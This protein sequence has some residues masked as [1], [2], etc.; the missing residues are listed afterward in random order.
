MSA[1]GGG[2]KVRLFDILGA[3]GLMAILAIMILPIPPALLSLLLIVNLAL[4][5]TVLLVATTV[6]DVLEFSVFPSV[7]LGLTLLRL[8]LN[9][10]STKL[11]LLTGNPGS[12]VEAFGKVVVRGDAVVEI[13]RASC[14]ER[15]S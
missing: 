9:L 7:L 5:V 12:V 10:A 8:A 14:R 6:K 11:I 1:D 4:S 15:V 3:F 2:G 13:G